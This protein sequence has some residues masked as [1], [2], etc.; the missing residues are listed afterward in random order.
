MPAVAVLAASPLLQITVED[1]AGE[2]DVHLHAGGQGFWIARMVASLGVDAVLCGSFGGESGHVLRALVEREGVVVRA[3]SVA[4]SNTVEVFD[5]RTGELVHVAC[6]PLPS[7]SRHELDDLY[8]LLLVE[9]L[10]ADVT[11]LAGVPG[12]EVAPSSVYRRLAADLTANRRTVIADV[13]GEYLDAVLEGG[14]P[15]IKVSEEEVVADGRVSGASDAELRWV[16]EHLRSSGASSVVLTRAEEPAIA[17][18]DGRL[19]TATPPKLE[20]LDHRG[21]GDA[22]TAG[23]A[24]ALARGLPPEGALRLGVAA[25]ALSVTRR[26]LATGTRSHIER[27]APHVRIEDITGHPAEVRAP[28]VP[29]DEPAP[30]ADQVAAPLFTPPSV[31]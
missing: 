16:V 21:A 30:S 26:G 10:A 2:A 29:A 25:G 8:N 7:L 4:G 14:H 11:V 20:P 24:A 6:T 12:P 27:L 3:V 19:V 9:A 18:F 23:L 28:T 15:I 17:A 1:R 13:A 31:P 22:L 5:R